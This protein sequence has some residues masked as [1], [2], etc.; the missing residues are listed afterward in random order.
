MLA[1]E[2]TMRLMRTVGLIG[3]GV[4]IGLGFSLTIRADSP[5]Q[6]GPGQRFRTGAVLSVGDGSLPFRTLLDTRTNSCYLLALGIGEVAS[7]I[8]PAPRA[9]CD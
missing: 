5:A 9:A 6:T 1:E 3:V 2:D 7:A 4:A 8:T